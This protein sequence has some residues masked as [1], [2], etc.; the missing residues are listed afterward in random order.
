MNY[1]TSCNPLPENDPSVR[2]FMLSTLDRCPL[3][4]CSPVSC[5]ISAPATMCVRRAVSATA[6]WHAVCMQHAVQQVIM[7]MLNMCPWHWAG[8]EVTKVRACSAVQT[9]AVLCDG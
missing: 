6:L 8:D 9:C 7:Y 3:L 2:G 1:V 5:A 4:T